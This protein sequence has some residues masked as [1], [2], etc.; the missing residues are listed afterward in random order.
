MAKKYSLEYLKKLAEPYLRRSDF[1]S[2]HPKEYSAAQQR[3]I[4]DDVCSHMPKRKAYP[5]LSDE[6]IRK[7]A[8]RFEWVG[9]FKKYDNKAYESARRRGILQDVCKDMNRQ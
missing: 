8:S 6:E 4:L 2:A 1:K 5:Q 9:D 7:R 3:G